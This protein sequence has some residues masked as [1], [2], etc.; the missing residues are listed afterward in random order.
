MSIALP[1]DAAGAATLLAFLEEKDKKDAICRY[2][3]CHEPRQPTTGT[4]RRSAYCGDPE[5]TALTNH[6]ARATLRT[7]AASTGET[8]AKNNNTSLQVGEASSLRTSVLSSVMGLQ[9]NLERY[10]TILAEIADPEVALAQIQARE[11]TAQ[12]TVATE[13]SSRLAAEAATGLAQ[14]E[15]QS[16]REAAELAIEQLEAAQARIQALEEETARKI[17]QIEEDRDATVERIRAETKQE[18]EKIEGQ[19]SEAVA[20]AQAATRSAQDEARQAEALK[21]QAQ[22]QAGT[23]ERLIQEAQT[24]LERER[25]EVDRLRT[26]LTVTID[27]ARKR[28]ESDRIEAKKALERERSE[29]DRLRTELT[30]ARTRADQL[31]TLADDLRAQL[32]QNHQ[33]AARKEDHQAGGTA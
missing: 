15:L 19:A 5:H 25:S 6:R 14:N 12:Q 8:T 24:A 29:V 10:V 17:A 33:A 11:A 20:L 7:L 1:K 28:E 26:E 4:G 2:P 21:A 18:I 30:T 32:L 16:E 23:A 22:A 9:Q 3:D 31:A 13:R 27:Q